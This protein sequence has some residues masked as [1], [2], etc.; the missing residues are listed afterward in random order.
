MKLRSLAFVLSLCLLAGCGKIP[1]TQYYS[2]GNGL[3][4]A[5]A[6]GAR[7]LTFDVA[8]AR[9]K[10]PQSLAQDRLLYRPAPNQV[11]YYAYHRWSGYPADQVTAAFIVRLRNAGLFRTVTSMDGAPKA[12]YIL[13]GGV[14]N[15]E[16]VNSGT[17]VSA[18]VV[19]SMEVVD[20]KTHTVVW[21]GMR[22]V[23]RPVAERSVPGVVR[24]LNEGVRQCLD[25]LIQGTAGYFKR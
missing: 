18:N 3:P 10:A 12:D 25:E 17:D 21:S 2:I 11:D 16:E 4:P 20:T 15:L 8:V 9:F 13:R 22:K 6:A 14:E 19:L 1:T 5:P 24:E 23:E 7:P